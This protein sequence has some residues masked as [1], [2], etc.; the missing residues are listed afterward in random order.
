MVANRVSTRSSSV[1]ARGITP[2]MGIW[3]RSLIS[4]G[5]V[6]ASVKYSSTKAQPMPSMSPTTMASSRFSMTLGLKGRMGSE[7]RSMM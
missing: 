5:L 6:M 7:A 2:R 3:N 4:S 1:L